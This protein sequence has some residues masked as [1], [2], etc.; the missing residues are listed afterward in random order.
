MHDLR[1]ALRAL[2]ARPGFAIVAVLTLAL[3]IG[4]NTAVFTVVN[5]VLLAPLPY[6]DP[7]RVVVLLEST[8]KFPVLSVSYQNYVDWRDRSSKSFDSVAAFRPTSLTLTGAGDPER[9]QAKMITAT[10]LP[11]LGV[12]PAAG[13]GFSASDDKPGAAGVVIVSD[14]FAVRRFGSVGGGSSSASDT[15]G[16]SANGNTAGGAV[17]QT[18]K[19]GRAHV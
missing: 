19:I 4:A 16:G 6:V 13:R 8:P 7:A 3:G 5:G 1:T 11:A 18:I 14:A 9:L 15:G 10:L 12:Q 17:G 2:I